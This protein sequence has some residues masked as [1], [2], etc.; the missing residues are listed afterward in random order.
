MLILAPKSV[1]ARLAVVCDH[2]YGEVP[3][4]LDPILEGFLVIAGPG[5]ASENCEAVKSR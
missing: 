3:E 5:T 1:Q 4:K 2:S